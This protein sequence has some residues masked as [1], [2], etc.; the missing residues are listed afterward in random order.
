[1]PRTQQLEQFWVMRV[2]ALSSP[3]IKPLAMEGA[4]HN[5]PSDLA[6]FG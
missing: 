2:V 3:P 6:I 4:I 5:R 1:M